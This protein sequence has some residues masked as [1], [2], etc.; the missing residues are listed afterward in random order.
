MLFAVP[1]PFT[2]GAQFGTVDGVS[3]QVPAASVPADSGVC[4]GLAGRALL[5]LPLR[6]RQH[7]DAV[8]AGRLRPV[9]ALCGS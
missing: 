8:L 2:A 7:H 5:D 1:L 6:D 4:L 9:A 3:P